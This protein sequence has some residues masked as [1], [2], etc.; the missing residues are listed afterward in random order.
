[1]IP[2]GSPHDDLLVPIFRAGKCVYQQP[3][4]VDVRKRC[5]AQLG[6]LHATIRRFDKPHEYPV[7]LE[8]RLRQFKAQLI[9]KA[10]GSH[11]A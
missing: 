8:P 7:G 1:V 11:T 5:A 6:S 9:A 4:L 2:A 10:R 3:A